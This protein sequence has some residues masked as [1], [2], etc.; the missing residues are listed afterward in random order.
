MQ[1]RHV[2]ELFMRWRAMKAE[3]RMVGVPDLMAIV[4]RHREGTWQLQTP[5]F[6]KL[7]AEMLIAA[8]EFVLA[9]E[10]LDEASRLADISPQNW[11]KPEL[12]RLYAVLAEHGADPAGFAPEH[13]LK[14]SLAQA[15]E[16]G[17]KY[18]ELCAARDLGQLYARRGEHHTAREILHAVSGSLIA[19][20]DE[21]IVREIHARLDQLS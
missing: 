1:W 14:R 16:H 18:A 5:F 3:N 2:G 13:W 15:R 19:D 20:S 8:G 7:I 10:L 21:P 11:V 9:K 12:Y 17:E 4:E 6:W